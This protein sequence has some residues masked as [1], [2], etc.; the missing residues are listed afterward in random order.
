MSDFLW[1][2][3][4]QHTKLPSPSL[5]PRVCSNSCLLSQWSHPTI[6]SSVVP[7]SSCPQPLLAS[8]SFPVN[9]FFAPDGQSTGVSASASV[10]LVNIQG[11]FP[12]GSTGLISCLVQRT[13]KSLLQDTVQKHQFFG[14]QPS[15]WSNAHIHIWLLKIIALTIQIFVGKVCKWIS[16]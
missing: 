15:L 9:Q 4:L 14:T 3:E 16:K 10:L 6:S 5:S 11:T 7:F 1:P 13:V 12:L 8:E 2:Y